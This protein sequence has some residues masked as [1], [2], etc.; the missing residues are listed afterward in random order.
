MK[1][2][3][4][5]WWK[6][7]STR[8]RRLVAVMLALLVAVGSWLGVVRPIDLAQ[9]AAEARQ[10][11]AVE[12]LVAVRTARADLARRGTAAAVPI[13]EPLLTFVGRSATEAGMPVSRLEGAGGNRVVLAV[14]AVRAPAFLGWVQRL[15]VRHGLVV[16]SLEA[17]RNVDSTI[18][19]QATL[20][21]AA[22]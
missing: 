5:S 9:E 16:E 4:E 7:L 11:R 22:D 17:T 12:A 21:R 19:A 1:A 18:A 14:T 15:E 8:E 20:R 6:R 2:A 10:A 13:D 3:I